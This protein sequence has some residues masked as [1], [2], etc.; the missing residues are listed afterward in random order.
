MRLNGTLLL[1]EASPGGLLQ[2]RLQVQQCYSNCPKY[3]QVGRGGQGLGR[4]QPLCMLRH[5][6]GHARCMV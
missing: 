1:A 4:G 6:L 5:E 2:L 3:I